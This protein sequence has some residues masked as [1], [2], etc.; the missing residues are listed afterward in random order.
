MARDTSS[1]T[2]PPRWMLGLLTESRTGMSGVSIRQAFNWQN[3]KE[4]W[5]PANATG[6]Q[7]ADRLRELADALEASDD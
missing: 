2:T 6:R 5:W 3:G 7:I 4:V 1:T